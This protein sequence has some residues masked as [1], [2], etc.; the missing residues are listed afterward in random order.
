M[1]VHVLSLTM[2]SCF[3]LKILVD[4]IEKVQGAEDKTLYVLAHISFK[5][6]FWIVL[7]ILKVVLL[8]HIYNVF[9]L[10]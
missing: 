8:I 2:H 1:E 4:G 7:Q 10:K 6:V 3:K 9:Q 5:M